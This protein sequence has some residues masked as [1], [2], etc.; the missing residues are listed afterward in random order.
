MRNNLTE[1][2]FILDRSGSMVGLTEDTVGGFN[3]LI[4]KQQLEEGQA[5]VSTVLFNGDCEVL[6]DRVDVQRIGRMTAQTFLPHGCTALLDAIGGAIRHIVNIH[7]YARAEDVPA[8]TVFVIMTDGMEN[9]SHRYS[10]DQVKRMITR[11]KKRYGWEF[12]FLGANID[13]VQTAGYFGIDADRAV[14]YRADSRGMKLSYEAVG[15]AVSAVRECRPLSA[16]W[17]RRVEEDYG[18]R[19]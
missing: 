18:N 8:K 12:L 17:K 1:M 5:L 15:N 6:H 10:A 4:Q 13:A 7:K 16:D 14:D 11:Q 2:V 9:A 3:S 19:P